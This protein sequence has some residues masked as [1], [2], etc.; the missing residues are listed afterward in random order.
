MSL[1]RSIDINEMLLFK[2]GD[3]I[4]MKIGL[5]S[6]QGYLYTSKTLTE[7][8]I[9]ERNKIKPIVSNKVVTSGPLIKAGSRFSRLNPIGSNVPNVTAI[10]VLVAMTIPATS[11][12][13]R[14]LGG[15]QINANRIM[16]KPKGCS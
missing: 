2:C 9:R 12:T 16:V 13:Q 3:Q 5:S 11:A 8:V 1:R 7:K 4:L 15:V 14:S 6:D 10:S